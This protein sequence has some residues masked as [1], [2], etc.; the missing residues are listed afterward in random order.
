VVTTSSPTI[1]PIPVPLDRLLTPGSSSFRSTII[2]SIPSS[3]SGRY[4][5]PET[6]QT[7]APIHMS[8]TA[9]RTDVGKLV[10]G[11]GF[12]TSSFSAIVSSSSKQVRDPL[13]TVGTAGGDRSRGANTLVHFLTPLGTALLDGPGHGAPA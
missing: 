8:V 3:R 5:R 1:A 6:N 12:V 9:E 13:P 10:V 2:V 7:P 4:T 11:A